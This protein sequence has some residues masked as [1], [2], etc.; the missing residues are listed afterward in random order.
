MQVLLESALAR[1]RN[2]DAYEPDADIARLT[3]LHMVSV[4]PRI[5]HSLTAISGRL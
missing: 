4:L 2:I 3:P 5:T 1:P